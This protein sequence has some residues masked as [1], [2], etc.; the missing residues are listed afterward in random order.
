QKEFEKITSPT[1]NDLTK[2][3]QDIVNKNPNSRI[4][5]RFY[6]NYNVTNHL[7]LEP[8]NLSKESTLKNLCHNNLV[9]WF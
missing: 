7:S 4:Y 8:F 2:Y 5:Y 1:F 9:E 3:F 6:S